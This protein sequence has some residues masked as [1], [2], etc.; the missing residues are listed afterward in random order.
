MQ[1]LALLWFELQPAQQCLR[2]TFSESQIPAKEGDGR[3][4]GTT[5]AKRPC[6]SLCQLAAARAERLL[7][8]QV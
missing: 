5:I 2:A 8:H 4:I 1:T 6:A 3:S 7:H